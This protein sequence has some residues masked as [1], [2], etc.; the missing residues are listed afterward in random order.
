[1]TL[2]RR[3]LTLALAAT[4]LATPAFAQAPL[5]PADK[6]LVDRAVA[7]LEG[8]SE[9]KARFVQTDGRGRST[10]G[11]LFMKRPGKARFAYDAPSGLL[12]VS[13]GGVVSVQDTRLKTFDQYP[14]GVTPLSLFLAKTIRLDKGVTISRVA[15]MADGFAI[16]ARDGKKETAGTITLSFT[17]TPLALAG[18]TVT[19]AQNRPTRVQLQGLERTTGLDRS[20]FVLKDPRPKN[21]G[22][23]KV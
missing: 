8:L 21:P 18:W 2:T 20:L 11:Q 17:D 4:P 7:Y 19:D 6:A 5:S 23:G 10:T 16:T 15:R 13:D 12:V 22:R 3:S 9:A 14:L 1:M